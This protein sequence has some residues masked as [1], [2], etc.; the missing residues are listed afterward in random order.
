MSQEEQQ[1][2]EAAETSVEISETP[3]VKDAAKAKSKPSKKEIKDMATRVADQLGERNN[4]PRQQI[5]KIISLCGLKYAEKLVEETKEIEAQGGMM[6]QNGERRR[7]MGG[8]FFQ[9]ARQQLPEEM[10]DRIFNSWRHAIN[11]H[12]KKEQQ[13][14]AYDF[15]QR[16]SM[17]EGVL[18]DEA[19]EMTEMKISLSGRPGPV[20][21]RRELVITTLDYKLSEGFAMPRGVPL[22]HLTE[23]TYVVYIASKH[24][25]NIEKALKDETDELLVEGICAFDEEIDKFAIYSTYATT[26]KLQKKERKAAKQAEQSTRDKGKAAKDKA[27]RGNGK[28]KSFDKLDRPEAVV[29]TASEPVEA[30]PPLPDLNLP[31]GVPPEVAQKL[32]DFMRAADTYRR[33]IATLEAKPP[34]QQHG[35]DMTRKLLDGI[36]RK[37]DALKKEH[38]I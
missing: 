33:K 3:E 7:T 17:L 28:K 22:P 8:V 24:W 11:Q 14:P 36:E 25:D 18:N 34:N 4:K 21:R 6:T 26:K 27:Q 32:G 9:L 20:E 5:A 38:N 23:H 30:P 35:L 2:Q 10:R 37:I 19:G 1:A 12:I 15:E 31:E 13:Y 16:A 29:Q